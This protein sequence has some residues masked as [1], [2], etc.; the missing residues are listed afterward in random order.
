MQLGSGRAHGAH[1][2]TSRTLPPRVLSLTGAGAVNG[3][4]V[5]PPVLS[6]ARQRARRS[7]ERARAEALVSQVDV[8]IRCAAVAWLRPS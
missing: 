7:G 3:E 1:C 6:R 8:L 2:K 4:F 5:V